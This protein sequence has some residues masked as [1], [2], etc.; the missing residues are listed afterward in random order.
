MLTVNTTSVAYAEWIQKKTPT[1]TV[2]PE[3][4]AENRRMTAGEF[5]RWRRSELRKLKALMDTDDE[6]VEWSKTRRANRSTV[7]V[8]DPPLPKL[9]GPDKVDVKIFYSY[10]DEFGRG[11][12]FTGSMI[13]WRTC[14]ESTPECISKP[15]ATV[16]SRSRGSTGRRSRLGA[17]RG[18]CAVRVVSGIQ[19]TCQPSLS[20]HGY[21]VS[22]LL[23]E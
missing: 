17:S 22:S 1:T 14:S 2:Q 18:D 12:A 21:A 7:I 9:S 20:A 4:G 5:E 11:I 13:L 6:A 19:M 15:E 16:S 8:L 23:R 10:L 3:T